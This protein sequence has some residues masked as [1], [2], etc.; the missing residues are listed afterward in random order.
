MRP[1]T[2]AHGSFPAKLV[3][4]LAIL[5]CLF[6]GAIGLLLPVVP[7][8][9]FLVIGAFVAARH[10]PAM[11]GWLRRHRAL[12]PHLDRADRYAERY[13]A[14]DLW[15]KVQVGALVGVRL[16]LGG[17]ALGLS[18]ARRLARSVANARYTS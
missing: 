4:G 7:G 6:V 15:R 18:L 3:A 9:L 8:L 2:A 16:A 11:D 1:N 13:G 10:F 17:I 5:V 14:L 12:G